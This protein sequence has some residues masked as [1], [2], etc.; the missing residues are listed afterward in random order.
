MLDFGASNLGVIDSTTS[1]QAAINYAKAR[2]SLDGLPRCVFLPAGKYKVS[3][4]ITNGTT[5]SP[6]DGVSII[7]AG[8]KSSVFVRS[9]DYGDTL[10]VCGAYAGGNN[11]QG[12][13]FVATGNVTSGAH[14]VCQQIAYSVV[15]DIYFEGG[16]ISLKIQ[17]VY[18]MVFDRFC[19]V[20]GGNFPGTGP[21]AGSCYIQIVQN[22]VPFPTFD[23]FFS[24]FHFANSTIAVQR[25][26]RGI[27][28]QQC[29]GLWFNNGHIIS[30]WRQC[31]IRPDTSYIAQNLQ[32]NNVFFDGGCNTHLQITG[33]GSVFGARF[34]LCVYGGSDGVSMADSTAI[35]CTNAR[36]VHFN[37]CEWGTNVASALRLV[38]GKYIDVKDCI[39]IDNA[40][41]AT[42]NVMQV[43]SGCSFVSIEDNTFGTTPTVG[44][45]LFLNGATD[46]LVD[47]NRFSEVTGA[48]ITIN[49]YGARSTMGLNCSSRSDTAIASA[50]TPAI[51]ACGDFFQISGT[52]TITNFP[53]P[54][55]NGRKIR[56]FFAAALTVTNGAA[57]KLTGSVNLTTTAGTILEM[58]CLSGIW[59][60]NARS[61]K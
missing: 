34:N 49:V 32:F 1:I 55:F 20:S 31:D 22:G 18:R 35:N 13:G 16:F 7:G 23:T 47:G 44:A 58:T 43:E 39:F 36:G 19:G 48:D 8:M 45:A 15:S 56:L 57:L 53:T 3:A 25:V 2:Y 42:S 46:M 5:G 14:L 6:S 33:A 59:Y 21:V 28:I 38:A 30:A 24:N 61:V 41:N 4:T 54:N 26:E 52:T 51:P 17:G 29:D 37:F 60:E 9:T 10:K 12:L 27:D 50:A 11:V 40:S